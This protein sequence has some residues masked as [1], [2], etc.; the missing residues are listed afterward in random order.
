[1]GRREADA[2]GIRFRVAVDGNEVYARVVNPARTRHDRRWFDEHVDLGG[3]GE[4]EVTLATEAAGDGRLAGIPGWS[5]VRVVRE[6]AR[7]RDTATPTRPN[8][9]LIVVDTLRADRL[10][11]YGATP[12]PSPTLDALAARG[13]LFETMVAQSSWTMPASATL[14]TGLHP[15]DHGL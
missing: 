13:V 2:V 4:A 10:G 15:R 3:D 12:S 7:P 6:T 1:P 11:C 5:D 9:V 14:L 8:V